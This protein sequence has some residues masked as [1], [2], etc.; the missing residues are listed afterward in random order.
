MRAITV[1]RENANKGVQRNLIRR[2]RLRI[3]LGG[4][5]PSDDSIIDVADVLLIYN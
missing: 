2:H 5:K 3:D 4:E 1:M